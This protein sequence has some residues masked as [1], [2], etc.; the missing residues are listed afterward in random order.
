MAL[1]AILVLLAGGCG[2]PRN[3]LVI[4][5][6]IE[7]VQERREA[8]LSELEAVALRVDRRLGALQSTKTRLEQLRAEKALL[9]SLAT[10]E[11]D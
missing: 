4:P 8:M 3:C 9:D 7:L 11:G 5:A 1:S 6:Q 10:E 2:Q